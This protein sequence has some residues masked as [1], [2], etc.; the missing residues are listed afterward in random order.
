MEQIKIPDGYQSERFLSADTGSEAE[1]AACFR[2][3]IR[4]SVI[5]S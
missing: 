4:Q 5:R 1:S 3:G 2:P